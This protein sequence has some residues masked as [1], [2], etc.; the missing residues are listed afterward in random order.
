MHDERAAPSM[1]LVPERDR[2]TSFHIVMPD[3]RAHSRGAA[4][5]AT[6]TMTSRTRYLGHILTVLRLTKL[7]DG[8]YLVVSTYR[9]FLGRFVKDAP[10][11]ERWSI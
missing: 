8:L 1:S 4:V 3:G 10:G 5:I 11:P 7:V 6:L 2:F 9:A